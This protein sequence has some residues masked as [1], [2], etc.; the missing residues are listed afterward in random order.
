[1]AFDK[2]QLLLSADK[3][4]QLTKGLATL[5]VTDPLQFLC[6]EALADVAR[7]TAGYVLTDVQQQGFIRALA[8]FR[9]YTYANVPPPKSVQDAYDYAQKE[10]DAIAKGERRNLPKTTDTALQPSSGQGGSQTRI[11]GRMES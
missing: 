5:S 11:P 8:V 1:M 9:A 2:D 6:D 10:L 3:V 4:S 7:L